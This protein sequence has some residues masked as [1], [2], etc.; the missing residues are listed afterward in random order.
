MAVRYEAIG[1]NG[2]EAN[3]LLRKAWSPARIPATATRV[4]LDAGFNNCLVAFDVDEASFLAW[5]KQWSWRLKGIGP[6]DP[7]LQFPARGHPIN[8]DI[9]ERIDNGYAYFGGTHR[10]GYD[11]LYDKD[12]QRA[13]LVYSSR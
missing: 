2:T 5:I 13:W 7:L 1:L 12:Q 6:Q 4:R 9:P 11:V 10:G 8:A 3:Q